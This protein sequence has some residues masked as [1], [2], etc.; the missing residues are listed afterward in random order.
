M[1]IYCPIRGYSEGLLAERIRIPMSVWQL[2]ANFSRGY[3]CSKPAW[4][5]RLVHF[6]VSDGQFLQHV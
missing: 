4:A 6:Q 1:Y 2:L 3:P 5:K